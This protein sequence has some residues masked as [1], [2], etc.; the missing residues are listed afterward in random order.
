M[1]AD[2]VGLRKDLHDLL[3]SRVRGHIIVSRFAI[4]KKIADASSG[5]ISLVAPHT[6]GA[7]DFFGELFGVRQKALQH[8]ALSV[9]SPQR[10]A[11][12]V[13]SKSSK[14]KRLLAAKSQEPK[15]KANYA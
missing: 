12:E 9:Q 11:L 13:D 6:Q 8:S 4:K 7:D 5:Q 14:L 3:R 1:L 10:R 2:G 15:A